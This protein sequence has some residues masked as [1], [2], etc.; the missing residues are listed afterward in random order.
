MA[1]MAKGRLDI[2]ELSDGLT[3]NAIREKVRSN[4]KRKD[5]IILIDGVYNIPLEGSHDSIR[6]ENIARANGLKGIAKG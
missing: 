3:M 6:E 2:L 4:P 1:D 5:T